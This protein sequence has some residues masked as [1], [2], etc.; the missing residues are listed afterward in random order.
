MTI[1]SK[2]LE[3]LCCPVTK[4]PVKRLTAVQ[5]KALNNEINRGEVHNVAGETLTDEIQEGLITQ[6]GKTIYL[7]EDGIPIMLED[8]GVNTDQLRDG[9]L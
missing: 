2:L 1:D 9:I 8:K 3:I 5:L 4:S 7:I 6:S